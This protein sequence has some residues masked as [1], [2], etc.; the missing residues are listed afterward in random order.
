MSHICLIVD[1]CFPA[2]AEAVNHIL[3]ISSI[4]NRSIIGIG[5]INPVLKQDLIFRGLIRGHNRSVLRRIIGI[6]YFSQNIAVL[7]QNAIRFHT[8]FCRI[9]RFPELLDIGV[10]DLLNLL[11]THTITFLCQFIGLNPLFIFCQQHVQILCHPVIQDIGIQ[12]IHLRILKDRE[13][14]NQL[15]KGIS[16]FT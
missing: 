10:K 4:N 13:L 1:D 2:A 5:Y 7:Y 3:R 9:I 8:G 11:H 16:G 15:I 14:R 12:G 6:H